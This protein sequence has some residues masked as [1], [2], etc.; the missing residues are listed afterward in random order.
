MFANVSFDPW[1]LRGEDMDYVINA[2]MHGG[3]VFLDD[4]WKVIHQPP[5]AVSEAI[6]FRQDVYRFVYEHRKIEFAQVAG[7][8]AAGDAEVDRC[9]IRARSSTPRWRGERS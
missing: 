2:R 5:E 6:R 8:P 7:R 1:V 4:E 9:R 3:D